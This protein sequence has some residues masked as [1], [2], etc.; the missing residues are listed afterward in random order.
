VKTWTDINGFF[1]NSPIVTIGI[2]D[3]VHIGHRR[4]LEQ[5]KISAGEKSRETVVITLWPHPR[6]VIN[7]NTENLR[8]L[9]SLEEKKILLNNYDIDHLVI[10]PFTQEFAELKSWQFVKKYLIDRIGM[11][12]LIVG[13]DHK[14]GRD[15]EGD[16]DKLQEYANIYNFTIEKIPPV[17]V[18]GVKVSSSLIRELLNSD[19]LSLANKYLGYDYFIQGKV[20]GGNKIG[21]KIGFPTANVLPLD[22][23]KLIPRDGVYAIHIN[24]D[25]ILHKGM[26]NVGFRPT[27]EKGISLKTIEVNLFNFKG[28]I[29][30]KQVTLFFRK[31]I[32]NEKKFDRIEQ[33]R[34]QL[35]KDKVE[36][37]KI[38]KDYKER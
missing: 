1:P 8:Y 3:G 30:E 17:S 15:R 13:Y 32:R 28:N 38:L 25:G 16:F 19:E 11:K 7:R 14:F 22:P 33:L 12:H 27:I 23:H 26:L 10:L 24:V 31:R 6:M 5:L 2:F 35:V 20:V 36:A 18:D 21:R 37:Q 4:L 29:Y 9:T 34:D